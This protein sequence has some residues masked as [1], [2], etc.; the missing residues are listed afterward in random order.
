MP[1]EDSPAS[2]HQL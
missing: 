2:C 1:Q